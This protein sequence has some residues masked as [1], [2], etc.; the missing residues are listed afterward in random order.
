MFDRRTLPY[1][2]TFVVFAGTLIILWMMG[3][4]VICPP[5]GDIRIWY[6][7]GDD[8][9]QGGSQ[10]LMDWYT[11]SHLIHG[12]LFYGATFLVLRK[13]ALGWRLLIATLV[14]CAWE[15]AENTEAVINRY[16]EFTVSGE[17]WGGDAVINSAADVAA[18]FVGFWLALRLPIWRRF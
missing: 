6:S 3:R 1:W 12:F 8:S 17:Y 15:I 5:C 13:L 11:P 7:G 2:A 14:E 4:N 16:R 9:G 18:M 10:H